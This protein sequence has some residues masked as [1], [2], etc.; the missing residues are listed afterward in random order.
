MTREQRLDEALRTMDFYELAKI[1]YERS[2]NMK[3]KVKQIK[4]EETLQR[5]GNRFFTK[6]Q[7]REIARA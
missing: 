3:I 7:L 1:T 2:N 6:E 5:F 4:S